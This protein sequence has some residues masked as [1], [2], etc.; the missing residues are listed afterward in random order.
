[1]RFGTDTHKLQQQHAAHL[2]SIPDEWQVLM[3]KTELKKLQLSK[4][5]I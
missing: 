2:A 3:Q 4:I 1:M 5:S